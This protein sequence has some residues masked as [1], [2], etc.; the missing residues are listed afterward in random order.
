MQQKVLEAATINRIADNRAAAV[1]RKAPTEEASR[2]SRSV[3]AGCGF[4]DAEMVNQPDEVDNEHDLPGWSQ[5]PSD[6]ADPEL[7]QRDVGGDN[8]GQQGC[9]QCAFFHIESCFVKAIPL[10]SDIC[11]E[12]LPGMGPITMSWSGSWGLGGLTPTENKRIEDS[13]RNSCG[14]CVG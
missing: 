9:N 11:A 4:D 3:D 14:V 2:L 1:A 13:S 7:T 12:M 5:E 6:E 8:N 10:D